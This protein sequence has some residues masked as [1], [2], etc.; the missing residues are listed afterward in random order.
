MKTFKKTT[1]ILTC[2]LIS[3]VAFAQRF[4]TDYQIFLDDYQEIKEGESSRQTKKGEKDRYGNPIGE[5]KYYWLSKTYPEYSFNYDTRLLKEYSIDPSDKKR[6]GYLSAKGKLDRNFKA[7]GYWEYYFT[8][9]DGNRVDGNKIAHKGDF[10]NGLENGEWIDFYEDGTLRNKLIFKMGD[11]NGPFVEITKHDDGYSSKRVGNYK[12]DDEDGEI[13][14]YITHPNGEFISERANYKDG[15]YIGGKRYNEK[16]KIIGVTTYSLDRKNVKDETY[17]DDG[18][19]KKLTEKIKFGYPYTYENTLYYPNGN[20]KL[21]Y[22]NEGGN[23]ILDIISIKSIDGKNLETGPLTNGYGTLNS[24]TDDGELRTIETFEDGL[25]RGPYTEFGLIE[26]D[27]VTY[28]Y[29]TEG[30]IGEGS[31]KTGEF[32][33]TIQKDGKTI[34]MQES[35][36]FSDVAI[37]QKTYNFDGNVQSKFTIDK[38][39]G[40]KEKVIYYPSGEVRTKLQYQYPDALLNVII[41]KGPNGKDL[42]YGSLKDGNGTY[43]DYDATGKLI[44]TYTLKDGK[45]TAKE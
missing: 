14:T 26:I 25:R 44:N 36:Y 5:W 28:K 43:K 13:I 17:Y 34:T 15:D 29:K 6:I 18:T 23:K 12:Y 3:S 1:A 30:Q 45:V 21:K 27:G 33:T 11:R 41:S 9:V 2:L 7:T 19:L 16:G 39:S 35:T 20:F 8:R 22:T 38:N 37:E 32:V 4:N 10:V 31:Q 42:D 40:I 24:Y